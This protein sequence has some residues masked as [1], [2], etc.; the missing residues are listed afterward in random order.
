MVIIAEILVIIF[1]A[2]KRLTLYI[3]TY[4][5]TELR[6]YVSG[7]IGFLGII[8]ILLA[9]KFI[10]EKKENFFTFATLLTMIIFLIGVNLINPDAYIAKQNLTRFDQT[11]KIDAL[12][13]MNLSPDAVPEMIAVYGKLSTEDKIVAKD[14]LLAHQTRWENSRPAGNPIIIPLLKRSKN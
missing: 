10:F 5:M 7:F 4:G 6:F 14:I 8:F 2:F 13:L 1:S 9:V 12:Y 3:D 11:G